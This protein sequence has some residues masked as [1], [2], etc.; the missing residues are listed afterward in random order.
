MIA[1]I[2]AMDL[3][4]AYIKEKMTNVVTRKILKTEFFVGNLAKKVIV[5][6]K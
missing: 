4:V 2:A 1:I 5:L 3:E 6:V